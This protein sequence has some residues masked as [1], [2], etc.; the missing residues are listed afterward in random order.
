MPSNFTYNP[1]GTKVTFEMQPSQM[2]RQTLHSHQPI[3]MANLDDIRNID[4]S[5]S[6][7]YSIQESQENKM[8][9]NLERNCN[10]RYD[11]IITLSASDLSPAPS[12]KYNKNEQ[13]LK[14]I[15]ETN[16]SNSNKRLLS[17]PM[18][19][20]TLSKLY[21]ST[22]QLFMKQQPQQPQTEEE[23]PFLLNVAPSSCGEMKLPKHDSQ[24]S[25]HRIITE[26]RK[27]D[28]KNLREIKQNNIFDMDD[29]VECSK[30]QKDNEHC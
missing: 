16:E 13:P 26:R 15:N 21:G 18:E 28:E 12:V 9:D 6:D 8:N 11:E 7:I 19:S 25:V 17:L 14:R 5:L 29:V 23:T 4:E 24:E 20:L 30:M 22:K 2:R 27:L 1:P 10:L 3:M